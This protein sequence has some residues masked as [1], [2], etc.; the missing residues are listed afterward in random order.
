[1]VMKVCIIGN[2]LTSL[3][4]AKALVNRDIFVDVFYEQNTKK[5]NITR[6]LGISESNTE[7]FSKN[8]LDIKKI[9][10]NIKKI[11]IFTENSFQNEII[12]FSNHDKPLFS[13]YKMIDYTN[14]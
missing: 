14:Y 6:T 3:A 8:I 1:M 7:Y 9:L 13:F 12:N 2:G 4:L 10:W 5:Y 11:K